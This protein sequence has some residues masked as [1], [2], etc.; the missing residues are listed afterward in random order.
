MWAIGARLMQK[1]YMPTALLALDLPA[2]SLE[3]GEAVP[4]FATDAEGAL[5]P[6]G[7]T[8]T[9]GPS[10]R[11]LRC[12]RS[13]TIHKTDSL[14]ANDKYFVWLDSWA[15]LSGFGSFCVVSETVRVAATRAAC[16]VRS[17]GMVE[18]PDIKVVRSCSQV[19]PGSPGFIVPSKS[20]GEEREEERDMLPEILVGCVLEMVTGSA[21][22]PK[23]GLGEVP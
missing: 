10:G 13:I 22:T 4:K 17:E 20:G 12:S 8:S 1:Q 14:A 5:R 19:D 7:W 21:L 15:R 9:S 16:A 18:Q 6:T 3:A 23:G 2:G 11:R